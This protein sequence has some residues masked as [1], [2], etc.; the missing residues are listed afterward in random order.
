M[1]TTG[2]IRLRAAIIM[3]SITLASCQSDDFF[4]KEIVEPEPLPKNQ[5]LA[6]PPSKDLVCDPFGNDQGASSDQFGIY[7]K[8][9]DATPAIG[10]VKV[11]ADVVKKEH[12]LPADLYF[13]RLNVTPRDF[14]QGFAGPDGVPL[15]NLKDETLYEWFGL[16]F[17][18]RFALTSNETAGYYELATHS[19]DGVIVKS[20]LNGEKREVVNDDGWHAPRVGCAKEFIYL[21]KNSSVEFE[22][23]YFQGPR[24]RISM[25]LYWRKVADNIDELSKVRR[26][27]MCGK[28]SGEATVPQLTNEGFYKLKAENFLLPASIGYNPCK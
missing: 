28:S 21:D 23:D 20:V 24:H 19:D 16:R 12:E 14:S 10:N 9:Y 4:E 26:S 6:P 27:S 18:G 11:V 22:I 13:S 17:T 1:K 15:K 3:L 7:A 25:V 5:Q 8:L 2:F